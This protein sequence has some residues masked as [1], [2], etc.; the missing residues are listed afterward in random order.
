[1]NINRVLRVYSGPQCVSFKFVSSVSTVA[2]DRKAMAKF[3]KVAKGGR[4]LQCK[5]SF[6]MGEI[7]PKARAPKGSLHITCCNEIKKA[8][9]NAKA[10]GPEARFAI[11]KWGQESY[12]GVKFCSSTI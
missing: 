9:N 3:Q 6:C 1:M 8:Y 7:P 5:C 10:L 12:I 4:K 11:C 2:H